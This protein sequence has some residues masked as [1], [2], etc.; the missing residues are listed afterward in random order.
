MNNTHTQS[1]SRDRDDTAVNLGGWSG[2]I[3]IEKI[4]TLADVRNYVDHLSLIILDIIV[5]M[6][7]RKSANR[8]G[9][10]GTV[11]LQVVNP[12]DFSAFRS[13]L[14]FSHMRPLVLNNQCYRTLRIVIQ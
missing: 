4:K 12:F 9:H 10:A 14:I 3:G 11:K 1:A 7:L 2:G 13:P 6:I 8:V 5:P